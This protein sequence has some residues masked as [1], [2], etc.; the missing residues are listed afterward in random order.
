MTVQNTWQRSAHPGARTLGPWPSTRPATS[1]RPRYLNSCF[2]GHQ[3]AVLDWAPSATGQYRQYFR[4]CFI[5]GY[6]DFVFGD[7]G[8]RPAD[9]TATSPR[10]TPTWRSRTGS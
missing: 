9:T 1:D 2:I 6:V 3:D 8:A 7:R 10:R 4:H 5:A